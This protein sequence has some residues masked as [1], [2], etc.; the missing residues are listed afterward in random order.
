MQGFL[1]QPWTTVHCT[2]GTGLVFTFTQDEEEWLDLSSYADAAF[3]VDVSDVVLPSGVSP[4]PQITLT[5]QTSP[6]RD[7]AYFQPIAGPIIL[8]SGNPSNKLTLVKIVRGT[9]TV[10][11]PRLVLCHLIVSINSSC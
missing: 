5:L 9:S 4:T 3:W 7:E 11:M 1:L 6:S 10:P 8:G 2:A